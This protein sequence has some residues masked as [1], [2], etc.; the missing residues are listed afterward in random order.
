MEDSRSPNPE[1]RWYQFSLRTLLVFTLLCAIPCSWVAV[2]MNRGRRQREVVAEILQRH[3]TASVTYLFEDTSKGP[4]I[5]QE[6]PWLAKLFGDDFYPVAGV[7]LSSQIS[8]ATLMQ[9]GKLT[10]LKWLNLSGT[11]ITEKGVEDLQRALP[12]CTIRQMSLPLE[13]QP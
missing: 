12:N 3:P 5:N 10:N 4:F 1:R 8:E 11:K 13:A 6:K 2:R 7:D 9:L